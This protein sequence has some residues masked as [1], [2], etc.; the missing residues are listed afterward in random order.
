MHVHFSNESDVIYIYMHMQTDLRV[1][2]SSTILDERP[3]WRVPLRQT[4]DRYLLRTWPVPCGS[5]SATAGASWYN[6]VTTRSWQ[7]HGD[8][9]HVKEGRGMRGMQTTLFKLVVP[10]PQGQYWAGRTLPPII[11][12]PIW[13]PMTFA[14]K[15][16]HY[17]RVV[18]RM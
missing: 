6:V 1:H 8:V 10:Y 5:D 12:L 3:F 11:Y 7:S 2:Q 13:P 16:P 14:V 9:I 17:C 15:M 18:I 4:R